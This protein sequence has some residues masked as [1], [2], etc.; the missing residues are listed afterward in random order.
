ML[1]LCFTLTE[2]PNLLFHVWSKNNNLEAKM[3]QLIRKVAF[4]SHVLVL[5]SQLL[6]VSILLCCKKYYISHFV[7]A[8]LVGSQT[9]QVIKSSHSTFESSSKVA[10]SSVRRYAPYMSSWCT[11][12]CT[13]RD[14]SYFTQVSHFLRRFLMGWDQ[15]FAPFVQ[16]DYKSKRT[17]TWL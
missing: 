16:S 7:T 13:V 17:V 15:N 10:D 9:C 12:E 3:K 1:T 2:S 5:I 14:Y 6:E 8:E 4:S 11:A